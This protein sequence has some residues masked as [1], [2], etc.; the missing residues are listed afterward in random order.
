MQ[1][2]QFSYFCRNSY[3]LAGISCWIML[4]SYRQLT[5]RLRFPT[6]SQWLSGIS[7]NVRPISPV[8]LVNRQYRVSQVHVI[9]QDYRV[10]YTLYDQNISILIITITVPS[11]CPY[12]PVPSTKQTVYITHEHIAAGSCAYLYLDSATQSVYRLLQVP[13]PLIDLNIL[14][15]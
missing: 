1:R 2:C 3:F 10:V 15:L 7:D 11:S 5:K 9:A 4:I 6:F 12:L 8:C 14:T 13:L